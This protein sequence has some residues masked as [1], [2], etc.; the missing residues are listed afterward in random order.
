MTEEHLEHEMIMIVADELS[1]GL[2]EGSLQ[3]SINRFCDK[4][5]HEQYENLSTEKRKSI[6]DLY[7]YVCNRMLD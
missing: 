2:D 1:T 7:S 6:K 5:Y 3:R 4:V